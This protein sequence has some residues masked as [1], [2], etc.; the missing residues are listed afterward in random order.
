MP[1]ASVELGLSGVPETLLWPLAMRAEAS[2]REPGF[3]HDPMSEALRARIKGDFGRFAA[4]AIWH[5]IRARYGDDLLRAYLE[6]FPRAQVVS[7]GEGLDTQFWRV[8]NG[9]VRWLSVDLPEVIDA[10]RR[11]LP[12][13]PRAALFA[14][15]AL[16]PGWTEAV[17]AGE[18]VFVCAAGLLMYFAPRA[19][20]GLLRRIAALPPPQARAELFFDLISPGMSRHGNGRGWLLAQGYRAPP[21]PF[22]LALDEVEA[23]LA[24]I[25]RLRL[26]RALSYGEAYPRRT[27]YEAM[28]AAC[29][30]LRRF[31]PGMVHARI[32]VG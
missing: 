8:D 20:L 24:R 4:P 14:G 7:L 19:A 12:A 5:A 30:P 1:E 23:K 2:R 3:F 29:L 6:R 31:A 32:G 16:E 18:G 26:I 28:M 17:E 22:S 25:P 10:R 15:S 21:M 27:P 9:A 11:L 13:H